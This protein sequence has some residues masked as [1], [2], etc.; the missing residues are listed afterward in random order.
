MAQ[1]IRD[2]I[3]GATLGKKSNFK[4]KIFDWEGFE[5]EFRQPNLRQRRNLLKKAKDKNGEVDIID[6]I[7]HSVIEC[8]FVPNTGDNV[9]EYEDYDSLMEQG[10]GSFVEV[11][12]AEI[13]NLMNLQDEESN[14]KN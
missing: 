12:G 14:E 4:T 9:F 8:T 7:V 13:S 3:R 6:F 5:V 1:S 2:K 11:F 10:S